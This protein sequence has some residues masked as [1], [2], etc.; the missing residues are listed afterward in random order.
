MRRN[1]LD[2]TA[3]TRHRYRCLLAILSHWGVN[4]AASEYSN[5]WP[6]VHPKQF[7]ANQ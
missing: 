2:T 3:G 6:K 5:A 4:Q 7:Q 1:L